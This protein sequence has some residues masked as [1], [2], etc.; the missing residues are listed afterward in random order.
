VIPF[1]QQ[2][3]DESRAREVVERLVLDLQRQ[4]G[5]QVAASGGVV[6]T[7]TGST[8]NRVSVTMP[9]N[10]PD[11]AAS[12]QV[13]VAS[14]DFFRVVGLPLVRGR[15]F[16]TQDTAGA[17]RVA[18]IDESLAQELFGSPAAAVGSALSV[19]VET[20]MR[21]PRQVDATI[22]GVAPSSRFSLSGIPVKQIYLP[23]AQFYEQNVTVLARSAEGP[24]VAVL[25][26]TLRRIAPAVA[27][28]YVGEGAALTDTMSRISRAMAVIGNGLAA[29]AL[30]LSMAGLYGVLSHV[31]AKRMRELAVRIA[32]GAGERRIVWLVLRDGLRPVVEGLALGLGGAIVLR[33]ILRITTI[34]YLSPIDPAAFG[35]VTAI[36]AIAALAAC[37][38]PA[39]RASRV[40][41]NVTLKES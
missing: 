19:R 18:I 33:Q 31:V 14:P 7:G 21:A 11:G 27:A 38:A 26:E 9:P 24:P 1:D 35:L 25:Q 29:F 41:P 17:P 4:P 30:I 37:Y 34:K 40:D 6:A 39:R 10:A 28:T 20:P 22:A 13:V 36:L 8:F 16:S 5:M 23:F 3:Y 15:A 12:P 2:Q 32:L